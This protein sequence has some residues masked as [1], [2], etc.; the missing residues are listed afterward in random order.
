MIT[1]P[2]DPGAADPLGGLDAD[3]A[4]PMLT[5]IIDL[6]ALAP[7]TLSGPVTLSGPDLA[8]PQSVHVGKE[9]R[10]PIISPLNDVL[11]DVRKVESRS[12]R[13]G[14]LHQLRWCNVPSAAPGRRSENSPPACRKI[15]KL[16]SDPLYS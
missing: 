3:D 13:H 11:R 4:I 1:T 10:L 6:A 7:A 14:C 9:A 5:E 2:H 16:H 15:P 8:G 12:A